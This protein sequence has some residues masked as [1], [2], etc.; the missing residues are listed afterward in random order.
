MYGRVGHLR[1]FFYRTDREFVVV[2]Q[3][4]DGCRLQK[5]VCPEQE[6]HLAG[7][8][9]LPLAGPAYEQ[10]APVSAYDLHELA[11]QT[12]LAMSRKGWQKIPLIYIVPETEQLSYVLNLPPG[13]DSSQ[14]QEAAYWEFDGNLSAQ[15][16]SAENFACV[17][18]PDDETGSSCTITGVRKGYLQEVT[19]IF[20]QAELVLADIIPAA[21]VMTYLNCKQRE[22]AGFKRRPGA[23]LAGRRILCCWFAMLLMMGALCLSVD[24][25]HY[26]QASTLAEQ[27]RNELA[28]LAAQQQEMQSLT[29]M[30]AGIAKREEK[31]QI[32]NR[33]GLPWYSL[34]VHLGTNTTQGVSLVGVNAGAEENRLHLEGQA[35]NYDCLAEFVGQ[36]EA[37]TAFLAKGVT[38]ENS[39]VV[40]GSGNEPDKV[41]FSV[42]VDWERENDGQILAE[43]Q[44][45]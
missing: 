44:V 1:E 43:A 23:G 26:W 4:N 15:G 24:I 5:Y 36:C 8:N 3:A 12:A 27:Q 10:L 19:D 22:A 35:L 31:M 34:L 16:L 21:D 33:Q 18:C 11:E 2:V 45:Q 14:R 42:S 38:L 37:D 32:L 17:C 13:L 6:W 20:A 9:V 29:T 7:E 28:M 41:K 25:V 40:Q 39:A 30:A